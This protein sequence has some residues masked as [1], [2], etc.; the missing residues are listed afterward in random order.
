M[1]PLDPYGFGICASPCFTKLL[2]VLDD[3]SLAGVDRM[4]R[5]HAR[6]QRSV[7]RH[8]TYKALIAALEALEAVSP[9]TLDAGAISIGEPDAEDELLAF[10][11][12]DL[13]TLVLPSEPT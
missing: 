13:G 10:V 6:Y 1:D 12:V 8:P 7:E 5:F 4:N 3:G 2:E 9:G 11:S